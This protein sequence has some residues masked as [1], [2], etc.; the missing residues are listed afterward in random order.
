MTAYRIDFES[1]HWE[2]PMEGIRHKVIIEGT[3]K[4]RLVE[5]SPAMPPHWCF[6]GHTGLIL[7]GQFEIEFDSGVRMFRAGD[8][9]LIP[10][11]EAHRHRARALTETVRAIF[12]EQT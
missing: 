7:E 10:D 6:R 11:G 12:V 1:L 3:R 5:Y 9:V 2:S 4:L 8:G